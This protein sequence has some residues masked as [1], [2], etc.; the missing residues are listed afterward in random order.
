MRRGFC[1]R[2]CSSACESAYLCLICT[3]PILAQSGNAIERTNLPN[4]SKVWMW[5]KDTSTGIGVAGAA[6][7]LGPGKACLSVEKRK[8]T[9]VWTAHYRTGP[10]GRVLI[11]PLPGWF[12][13]RITL[14]GREL[15][16]E[17]FSRGETQSS[18]IAVNVNLDNK[19]Q[20]PVDDDYW[21]TTDDP[22][23]FRQYLQDE[24][25]NL[26]AGVRI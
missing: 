25:Q 9:P 15:P 16:V 7:D 14:N 1:R 26:I 10:A 20:E 23:V 4:R 8:E 12:S 18:P 13:C 6:V 3:A 21:D 11:D 24:N 5:V 2:V 17:T 22:T 19:K